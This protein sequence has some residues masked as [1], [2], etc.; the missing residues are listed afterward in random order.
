TVPR[1]DAYA[2]LQSYRSD[3]ERNRLARGLRFFAGGTARARIARRP[4]RRQER[5]RPSRRVAREARALRAG[6]RGGSVRRPDPLSLPSAARLSQGAGV[7]A[8]A[9]VL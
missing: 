4:G 3:R 9:A 7:R 8:N 6:G 2:G 5:R 1:A